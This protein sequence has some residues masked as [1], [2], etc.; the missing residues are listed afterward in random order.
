[1]TS[2]KSRCGAEHPTMARGGEPRELVQDNM[3][4]IASSQVLTQRT[5]SKS[6]ASFRPGSVCSECSPPISVFFIIKLTFLARSSCAYT[7]CE[8]RVLVLLS[9]AQHV[10]ASTQLTQNQADALNVI[11]GED[12]GKSLIARKATASGIAAS[13]PTCSWES[14]AFGR[15]STID[16]CLRYSARYSQR[17][18][19]S[20]CGRQTTQCEHMFL[21]HTSFWPAIATCCDVQESV[22]RANVIAT[23]QCAARTHRD[24]FAMSQPIVRKGRVQ[25]MDSN[26]GSRILSRLLQHGAARQQQ[27]GFLACRDEMEQAPL[28]TLHS[29]YHNL[30]NMTNLSQAIDSRSSIG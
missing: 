29:N 18:R 25:P 21:R 22:L 19:P 13:A 27:L 16:H 12:E 17:R 5:V 20:R 15:N 2:S 23:G 1:M 4:L 28:T 10:Q 6:I 24:K 9:N 14:L 8:Y 7:T 3:I 30:H 11:L 26:I